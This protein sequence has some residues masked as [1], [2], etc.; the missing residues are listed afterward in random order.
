[1]LKRAHRFFYHII[2][3]KMICGMR[4]IEQI[5][6][7]VFMITNKSTR[8]EISMAKVIAIVNSKG[9][10]GKTTTTVS[11]A[12]CISSKGK[13]VL[14]IDADQQGN[15]TSGFGINKNREYTLYEIMTE[16]CLIKDAVVSDA[17]SGVDVIP[18]NVNL[19]AVQTDL[20]YLNDSQGVLSTKLDEIKEFYDYVFIDCGPSLET[21][22][23]NVFMAADSLI[24]PVQCEYYALEGLVQLLRIVKCIKN[25]WGKAVEIEGVLMTMASGRSKMNSE[26]IREVRGNVHCRIF[27]TVI[28]RNV[29]LAEASSFGLPINFYDPRSAG[30]RA[31]MELVEEIIS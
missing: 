30:A 24:I 23:L 2:T 10:V 21:M 13:K 28:P 25:N 3:Q 16:K 31:Y 11:L 19:A 17:I 8:M 1:M 4:L 26:V 20:A 5:K 29:R 15:L 18:S 12:S 22:T 14:A 27:D 9:G 6:L 7:L